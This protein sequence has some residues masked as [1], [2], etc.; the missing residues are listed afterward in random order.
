M[1]PLELL[2]PAETSELEKKRH[3]TL[4]EPFYRRQPEEP[5]NDYALFLRYRDLPNEDRSALNLSRLAT[6]NPDL[7]YPHHNVIAASAK[8]QWSKRMDAWELHIQE[9]HSDRQERIILELKSTVETISLK[10][11]K[12]IKVLTEI[13]D[14]ADLH[15]PEI[16]RDLAIIQA[17]VGVKGSP[18]KFILDAYSTIIGEKL[19]L[20]R[21]KPLQE[22][23]WK[24][25][26]DS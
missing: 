21:G 5:A 23:E 26:A 14:P 24:E 3:P 18:G 13:S 9:A 19:Q 10:M 22:L 25:I 16:Q 2:A 20:S 15:K 1:P 12:K 7:K 8:W 4:I 6:K 11:I 17:F